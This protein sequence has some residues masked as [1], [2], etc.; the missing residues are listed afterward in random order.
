VK[1][2]SQQRRTDEQ[3]LLSFDGPESVAAL[4]G[5]IAGRVRRAIVVT[6]AGSEVIEYR[7]QRVRRRSIGLQVDETGLRVRAPRWISLREIE[8]AVAENLRWIRA[9]QREWRERHQRQ[10][11]VI[12]FYDG[13]TLP[14]LGRT[15]TL[16]LGADSTRHDDAGATLWLGLPLAAAATQVRQATQQWL[17]QQAHCVLSQRFERFTDRI[18]VRFAG[19]RMSSARTQWG[20]CSQDGRI[21]LNWRL[22]HFAPA[23]IDYVI[24]HELAHLTELNHSARFWSTVRRLLPEFEA[25]RDLIKR[26]PMPGF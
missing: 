13:G 24:A 17:Q 1:R 12:G 3:L 9:K 2:S 18:D 23:I 10:R 14:Y 22:V 21:R 5:D 4:D 16:R 8:T 6:S 25:A 7:L 15:I 26:V 19:W 11:I 20:S